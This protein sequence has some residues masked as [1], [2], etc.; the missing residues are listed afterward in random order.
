ME[1]KVLV[2]YASKYG[3]TQEVAD[4]VAV[5]LRERGLEVDLQH[6]RKVRTLVGYSAAVLGAPFYF[7]QWLKDAQK[8]L[9]QHREA[10]SKQHVVV[11]ALGPTHGDEQER[12]GARTQLDKEIAKFPW[13]TPVALVMFGGKYNPAKLRFP[14]S[15]IASLPASPLH[16]LPASDVRDWTAIRSWANSLPAKLQLAKPQ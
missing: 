10:L 14:D 7:G 3:S 12:Q 16:G 5:T 1:N 2:A 9:A 6:M 8:F 13:L 4:V 11:F 15:L